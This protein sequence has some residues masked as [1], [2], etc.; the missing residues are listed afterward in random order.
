MTPTVIGG[1][2]EIARAQEPPTIG[3]GEGVLRAVWAR[4][5]RVH[6]S[7]GATV[8]RL[9]VLPLRLRAV[10]SRTD[11]GFVAEVPELNVL[12]YGPDRQRALDDLRDAVRDYLVI[13]RD[14]DAGL[15][16]SVAH[17]AAYVPLLDAPEESWFA[18]VDL[19]GRL[20]DAPDVE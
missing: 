17:H 19:G 18:A 9:P 8:Y 13:V 14:N 5:P 15:A 6:V 7:E 1:V 16:P 20:G 11:E 4:Y 2:L 10:L 12:G 3:G